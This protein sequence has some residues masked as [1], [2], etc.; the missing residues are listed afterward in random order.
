MVPVIQSERNPPAKA[1][2]I[3]L[4][5]ISVSFMFPKLKYNK[6]K[7]NSNTTGTII[8]S[9]LEARSLLSNSPAHFM[10]FSFG[11]FTSAA[12]FFC[13]SAI[14]LPKSRP[15]ILKPMAI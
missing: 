2:G 14:V 10:V 6:N 3:V 11:S 4:V 15:S 13:A 8:A 1:Y 5:A 7:I 12:T 9:C